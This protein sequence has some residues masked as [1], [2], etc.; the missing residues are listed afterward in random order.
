[1]YLLSKYM[2]IKIFIWIN[3]GWMSEFVKA[4]IHNQKYIVFFQ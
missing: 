3:N 4:K 2:I 1:M